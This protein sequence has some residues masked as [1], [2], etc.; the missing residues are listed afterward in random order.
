MVDLAK[1]AFSRVFLIEGRATPE[2]AP[3]YQSCMRAASVEQN[4]GDVQRVEC[5]SS[6]EY[7]QFEEIGSIQGA[8]ERAT[9]SLIGRYAA[10]I[11]SEL[12]RLARQRC[13]VDVQVH[14]GKCT[15]PRKFNTFTKALIWEDVALTSYGTEDL[16]ALSSDENAPVGE[17]SNI[18]I[19]RFYEVLPLTLQQRASATVTNALVDAVVCD[20]RTCGEC[21]MFSDGCYKAFVLQ[22]GITGSPGTAPDVIYT[23]DKGAVWNSDEITTLDNIQTANGIACLSDYVVVVSN[24]S[25]SLHYKL[26]SSIL[27]GTFGSWVEKA[28][29]FQVPGGEPNDIWSVGIGAFIVGDGGYIYYCTD[30]AEGVAVLDEGE[31][32]ANNLYAVHALSS[33]AAIAVGANDTVVY[34]I[35]GT[36]WAAANATGAGTDLTG[37]WMRTATEWWVTTA[38]GHLYYTLDSGTTWTEK[39]LPGVSITK[40]EDVQFVTDSVGYVAGTA[41]AIGALWRTY[42]AGYSWV[43]LPEG[44]GSLP[45]S[46]TLFSALAGCIHDPNYIIA[47]GGDITSDGVLL[48]G[49]D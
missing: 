37:C 38:N 21:G 40:L 43:R 3:Q 1:T 35:N 36:S 44:A 33:T 28:T 42:D 26:K 32:T 45:G 46:A 29:G 39:T 31:A 27:A 48:V 30:P 2:H 25:G 13:A 34:T 5:P 12:L 24:D 10:D 17:T 49:E 6:D 11:A 14:F 20:L 19:G 8:I 22:G 18:S 47:A 41:N 9:S 4:F 16:G 23:G 15:D 7:G